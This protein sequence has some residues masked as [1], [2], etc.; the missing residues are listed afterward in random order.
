MTDETQRVSAGATT[1]RANPRPRAASP[2]G[3]QRFSLTA[4]ARAAN[5]YGAKTRS[6]VQCSTADMLIRGSLEAHWTDRA[7]L[8]FAVA[9]RRALGAYDSVSSEC[10][11]V[12]VRL[13]LVGA[14]AWSGVVALCLG[15]LNDKIEVCCAVHVL[16][17]VIETGRYENR[18]TESS[19][20]KKRIIPWK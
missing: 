5:G 7:S 20:N 19:E 18:D 10:T 12:C 1:H 8:A 9:A 16:Q 14:R 3:G 11:C 2:G 15:V 6:A 4:L 13:W 17:L